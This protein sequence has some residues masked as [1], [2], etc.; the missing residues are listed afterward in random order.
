MEGRNLPNATATTPAKATNS[1]KQTS[2]G[3]LRLPPHVRE[4]IFRQLGMANF[5]GLLLCCRTIYAEAAALLYST[6]RFFIY[7]SDPGSL[8]PLHALTP[9]SLA[10]LTRLK[11]ILNQ[12]SCHERTSER[13]CT[14][15][16]CNASYHI[17]RHR[18]P[19]AS[20]APSDYE[21]DWRTAQTVLDEWQAAAAHMSPHIR[22]GQLQLS[23]VC[24][25]DH[26]QKDSID[27]GKRV[28]VPL[29]LLP[30]LKNCSIRLC[31][32]PNRQLRGLAQDAALKARGFT[33]P[34]Y[35][36]HPARTTL[37]TLPRELRVR[38]LEYTDLITPYKEV[39]W[40]RNRPVYSVSQWPCRI[41]EFN[42]CS[43]PNHHGCQFV[44]CPEGLHPTDG[45]FCGRRHAAFSSECR[46]WTAPGP[47]LFLVCRTLCQDAQ[48]VFFSG[49][50]FI[51][52][53]TD[54]VYY[55]SLTEPSVWLGARDT[56]PA[57]S[58]SYDCF[59]ISQF[60]REIVP[61]HCLAYIRFLELVFP[62]YCHHAWP[63][64]EHPAMQDWYATVYWLKDKINGPKLTLRLI[65]TDVDGRFLKSDRTRLT[66]MEGKAIIRAYM[67]ISS[68]LRHLAT[69][70]NGLAMFYASLAYPWTWTDVTD[71]WI[72]QHG[73]D[74]HGF[75]DPKVQELNDFAERY[76]M[77]GRY[78]KL[79]SDNRELPDKSMWEF[80][81]YTDH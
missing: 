72:R 24:D 6:N 63:R 68:P 45:C 42:V 22:A 62:P 71:N 43:F 29:Q 4:R 66:E 7:Y 27:V 44:R 78:E 39:V 11:V 25:I 60:V 76:V 65:M 61:R 5:H 2:P 51:V 47:A 35:N 64:P 58:Y 16:H 50:R 41:Y 55:D 9:T 32:T 77:G 8:K 13:N 36:P 49:N 48:L 74:W 28:V 38:I 75:I 56:Q 14:A 34:Y 18:R 21:G 73:Y 57:G 46:C 70:D 3:L 17:G 53:D 33:N 30:R 81:Y 40:T 12:A 23:L 31:A 67:N 26:E 19:L 15:A 54:L 59:A 10:S 52:G 79:Y 1:S 37:A 80:W 20:C 69:G